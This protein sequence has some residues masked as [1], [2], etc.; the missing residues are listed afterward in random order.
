MRQSYFECRRGWF[1][2]RKRIRG[3]PGFQGKG[4]VLA[5]TERE[6]AEAELPTDLLDDFKSQKT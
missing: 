1:D 2:M 5:R 3:N 4:I 6:L